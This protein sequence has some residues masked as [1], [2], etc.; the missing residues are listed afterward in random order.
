M[1]D[2]TADLTDRDAVEFYL[3]FY[4]GG[5]AIFK[6]FLYFLRSCRRKAGDNVHPG[7]S[8]CAVR[9]HPDLKVAY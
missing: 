2:F 1:C 6:P 7:P 3:R 4:G 8:Q 9:E 5:Q